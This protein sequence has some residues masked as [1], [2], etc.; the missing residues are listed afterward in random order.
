[1]ATTVG[2]GPMILPVNYV[3]DGNTVAVRTDAGSGVDGSILGRVAFE[4][5]HIDPE[6]HEGWSVVVRG[7]ARDITDAVDPLSEHTRTLPL[8]PWAPGFKTT[9]IKILDATITGRRLVV[10]TS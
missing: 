10:T 5:D 1:M 9:W 3:M 8:S 4:V 7:V 2:G 6:S